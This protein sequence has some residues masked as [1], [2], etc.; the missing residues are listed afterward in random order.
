MKSIYVEQ[1]SP[2]DEFSDI[3]ALRTVEL[4][5]YSGGRMI[6]MELVDRTGRIKGVL[7]EFSPKLLDTLKAGQIYRIEGAVGTYKGESQVTIQHIERYD[8]YDPDDFIPRGEYSYDELE[9]RLENSIS[10]IEDAD[11][12]GLLENL[13]SD[14]ELK[15]SYLNGVGGKLWHHNYIGGLAEHSLSMFELCF[16]FCGNYS[17]L[18]AGLLLTAAL[19]HDIGKIRTYSIDTAIDY[20]GEGRLLGHIVIGDEIIREA[21]SRVKDFPESKETELRHLILA[22][23]G[24]LEQASPVVPKMAEAVALYSADL[25]DS[26]LAAFRRIRKKEKRPGVEWSNYVNLLDTH[27]Y[28]G[29]EGK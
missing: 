14:A 28:F 17:E 4:K 23:Q 27:I 16:D 10:R 3:F 29:T 18:D 2:G 19:I 22:H 7:W 15:K 21:I 1:L 24:T 11:Y 20:T 9:K 26:K 25:L 13:F 8:D 6:I 5:E 12:R